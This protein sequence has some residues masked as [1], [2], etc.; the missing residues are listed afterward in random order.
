MPIGPVLVLHGVKSK[1]VPL[2]TDRRNV[3]VL[4][5]PRVATL[6]QEVEV[7]FGGW[8][9]NNTEGAWV[10]DD[11]GGTLNHQASLLRE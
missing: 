9:S 1:S 5:W 8:Q 10:F 11:C 7:E 4:V 2:F 3:D 6:D